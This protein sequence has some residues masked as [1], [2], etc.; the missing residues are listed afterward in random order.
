MLKD[1][2]D[3]VKRCHQCQIHADVYQQPPEALHSMVSPWPFYMWGMDIIG[4]FPTA[5][6]QLK[7]VVVAI[8]YFT[9]WIEAEAITT[10]TTARVQK[11]FIKNI[12][13]RFGVPH[14]LVTDNG[15]QFTAGTFQELAEDL[16]IHHCFTSVEHPQTNGQAEA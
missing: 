4:K 13:A 6:G 10:I 5:P 2:L 7:F 8:D 15:T 3:H 12:V 11:F 1:S 9:K 16:Q 14:T